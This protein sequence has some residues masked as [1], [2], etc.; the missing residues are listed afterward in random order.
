MIYEMPL[1]G[2]AGGGGGSVYDDHVYD[3]HHD[4]PVSEVDSEFA[5]ELRRREAEARA[6]HRATPYRFDLAADRAMVTLVAGDAAR[7]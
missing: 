3:N 7:S 4:R 5:R 6:A 2:C 1:A